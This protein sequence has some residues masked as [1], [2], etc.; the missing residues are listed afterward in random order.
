MRN[1]VKWQHR[2]LKETNKCKTKY[3]AYNNNPFRHL[4]KSIYKIA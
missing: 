4:H 2:K 1:K 3:R